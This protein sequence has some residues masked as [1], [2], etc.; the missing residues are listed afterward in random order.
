[1][2]NGMLNSTLCLLFGIIASLWL[3]HRVPVAHAQT[4]QGK[5]P[6]NTVDFDHTNS[7]QCV[8]PHLDTSQAKEGYVSATGTWT[9]DGFIDKADIEFTCVHASV[10]QVSGSE[11]GYCL[12]ASAVVLEG[13][14]AVSTN[15]LK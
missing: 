5:H 6:C 9:P 7:P 3:I 4:G 1:M 12:M 10:P 14:P 13:L 2:K 15:Y 8:L 11:I